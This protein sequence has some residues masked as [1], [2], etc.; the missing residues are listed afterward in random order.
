MRLRHL[1]EPIFYIMTSDLFTAAD[2]SSPQQAEG[3]DRGYQPLAARL[4]PHTLA[5]FA[6]QA[7]VLAAGKPLRQ[8]IDSGQLHS[9][10]FWGPPGVGKTT[11]AR[12]AAGHA[13]AHF[14]QLSA[15]LSGVK[16]IREAVAQARQHKVAGSR[17]GIVC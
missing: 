10:I 1:R 14:L 4:R 12:L 13:N 8:A 17:Y 5:D 2:T 7:H 9:M 16:D 11:L 3:N 15:V 6:G